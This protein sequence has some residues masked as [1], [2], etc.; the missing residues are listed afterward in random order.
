M[1]RFRAVRATDTVRAPHPRPGSSAPRQ[2]RAPGSKAP[3]RQRAPA[4]RAGQYPANASVVSE[5]AFSRAGAR[6]ATSA[7]GPEM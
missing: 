3:H 1:L 2:Q 4:P 5:R 7:G 6:S